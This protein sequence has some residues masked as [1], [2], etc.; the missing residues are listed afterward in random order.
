MQRCQK[1]MPKPENDWKP[2]QIMKKKSHR[3]KL[4]QNSKTQ[5]ATKLKRKKIVTKL[6]NSD[7]DK[8]QNSS[9][10]KTEI[11]TKLRNSNGDKTEEKQTNC[12]I[13]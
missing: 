8:T 3:H 6:K 5:I 4:W 7:C 10:D 12:D 13:T 11:V 2:T 1:K 9:C